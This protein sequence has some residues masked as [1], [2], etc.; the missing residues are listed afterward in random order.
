MPYKLTWE[1]IG[2]YR[3]YFGRVSIAERRASF[4]AICGDRRFDDLRYAITDYLA[5]Q[6]YEITKRATAEIAA[7]HIAPLVTNPRIVIAAVTDRPEIVSAIQEFIA[8]RFIAAPYRIFPTLL[9]ARLWINDEL[10]N[11]ARSGGPRAGPSPGPGCWPP[12]A[13]HSVGQQSPKAP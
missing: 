2:L 4:D 7:F 3:E 8:Y 11:M 1:P 13:A 9:E 5:V 12:N 6:T 10:R